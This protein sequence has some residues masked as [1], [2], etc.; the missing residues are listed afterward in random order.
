MTISEA[1][2]TIAWLGADLEGEPMSARLL[3]VG[4][5]LRVWYRTQ[6][7]MKELKEQVADV[8]SAAAEAAESIITILCD[9]NAT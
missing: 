4:Y 5:S 6:H 8:V 9:R 7:K 1:K 2:A 3:A